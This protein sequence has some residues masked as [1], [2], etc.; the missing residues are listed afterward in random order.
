MNRRLLFTIMAVILLATLPSLFLF[1]RTA[2]NNDTAANVDT[3]TPAEEHDNAIYIRADGS[4]DPAEASVQRSEDIYT[5]TA[6]IFSSKNGI[7]IERDNVTLDGA[8]HALQGT[9]WSGYGTG[10]DLSHRSNIK[11]R[12]IEIRQFYYGI[13]L[14]YSSSNTILESNI[15][16]NV[17]GISVEY[18]NDSSISGSNV[19][20]NRGSAYFRVIGYGI[21]LVSSN[22]NSIFG[23]NIVANADSGIVISSSSNNAIYENSIANHTVQAIAL[24]GSSSNNNVFGNSIKNNNMAIIAGGASNNSI[25]ANSITDNSRAIYLMD[26]SNNNSVLG[27]NITDNDGGINI[28]GFCCNNNSIFGNNIASNDNGISL[29]YSSTNNSIIGNNITDSIYLNFASG[30]TFCHNNFVNSATSFPVIDS[31]QGG[32]SINAWDDGL[33]GNYWS[34]YDGS[35]N[36]GDGIGDVPYA[37]GDVFDRFPL[38]NIYRPN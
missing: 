1:Q 24:G 35:D 6:N 20:A 22:N 18:S 23:N 25:S 15:T 17:H 14:S 32:K 36:N 29:Q 5:L 12:N 7:V 8:D 27:N 10:I 30:N 38:I 31:G 2:R 37:I 19:T 33:E 4:I 9:T 11:I 16:N 21:S 28:Q 26:Y 34:C 13:S 3:A